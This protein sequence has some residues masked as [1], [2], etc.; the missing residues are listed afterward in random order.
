MTTEPARLDWSS[1]TTAFDA[2]K[3]DDDRWSARDLAPLAGYDRWENFNEACER[4]LIAMEN[5]FGVS[6]AQDHIRDATKMVPIGSG[7]TREVKD[8]SL[9]RLGAYIV[10][11]NGDP[12]KPEIA[13]SQA[14]FAISTLILESFDQRVAREAAAEARNFAKTTGQLYLSGKRRYEVGVSY[15]KTT[16]PGQFKV[17]NTEQPDL[18]E[19]TVDRLLARVTRWGEVDEPRILRLVPGGLKREL[20]M[21]AALEPWG[22]PDRRDRFYWTPESRAV[23]L[24]FPRSRLTHQITDA[25]NDALMRRARKALN[26]TSN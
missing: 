17:G 25:Y 13:A 15:A 11:M 8:Y 24:S 20:I 7:A 19:A 9:T 12:R 6:T 21:R 1:E 3:G 16:V 14:Y 22:V 23:L 26:S 5:T 4:G 10:F 2:I 18:V